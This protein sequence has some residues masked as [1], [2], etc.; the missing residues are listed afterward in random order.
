MECV[1][2]PASFFFPQNEQEILCGVVFGVCRCFVEGFAFISC[3]A[4]CV[5]SSCLEAHFFFPFSVHSESM[6]SVEDV[7]AS[8]AAQI[9]QAAVFAFG[10]HDVIGA[11]DV[12]IHELFCEVLQQECSEVIVCFEAAVCDLEVFEAVFFKCCF[13][14]IVEF[15]EADLVVDLVSICVQ[16]LNLQR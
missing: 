16:L 4:V 8:A 6:T 7:C 3:A 9:V 5:V 12:V 2:S 1:E 11:Q 13:F 10:K 14:I 15:A